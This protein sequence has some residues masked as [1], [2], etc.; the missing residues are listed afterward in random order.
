MS[1][2]FTQ[3]NESFDNM[4]F[5]LLDPALSNYSMD[6]NMEDLA[7]PTRQAPPSDGI[8]LVRFR[9]G[10][11][12]DG[13]PVYVKGS[14]LGGRVVEG[15][16]KVVAVL[17]GRVVD[18]VTGAEGPFLQTWYPTSQVFKGSSGS[19]ITALYFL[20]T[21][22]PI[23]PSRQGQA[24]SPADIV[25]AIETL[26]A[27]AGEEGVEAWAKTRWIQRIP[28]VDKNGIPVYKDGT[29]YPDTHDIK[30]EAKIKKLA[31]LNGISE[32][33]AHLFTDPVSGDE[34]TAYAEVMN[35]EDPSLFEEIG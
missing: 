28:K 7:K 4:E 22:K 17:E 12:K 35:L 16:L 14:K 8:H 21:G 10:T 26:F 23:Q 18:R 20:A 2:E 3:D 15:T 9:L 27:E 29:E 6:I 25:L 34:K 32:D 24:P 19:H 13:P 31:A 30:G 11:R 1:E 33:R 5:D